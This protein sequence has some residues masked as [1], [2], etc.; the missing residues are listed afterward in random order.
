MAA[1]GYDAEWESLPAA[2]V[3]APHLRL[4]TWLVA[5]PAVDRDRISPII[6]C[7]GRDFAQYRSWWHTEPNVGRVAD[8][9]PD[10]VDRMSA[11]GNSLTPQIVEAIGAAIRESVHD[12]RCT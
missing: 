12:Q 11:L 10:Q 4:R 6:F 3:G 5:Y 7:P 2:H 8:G 9:V 1:I